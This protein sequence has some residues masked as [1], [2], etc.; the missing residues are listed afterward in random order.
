MMFAYTHDVVPL[1]VVVQ[2]WAWE[3]TSHRTPPSPH[4]FN[5][6]SRTYTAARTC[7]QAQANLGFWYKVGK[8]GL[9]KDERK[10]VDLY[11]SAA[12]R[13][14]QCLGAAPSD[15]KRF[16]RAISQVQNPPSTSFS[17]SKFN[18]SNKN[19]ALLM[20]QFKQQQIHQ[21]QQK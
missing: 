5:K 3:S 21:Q 18:N 15:L 6:A 14:S 11:S 10:A 2:A 1:T 4:Y 8:G 12:L 19:N 13:S 7:L 17:N 20:T 16:V 9:A